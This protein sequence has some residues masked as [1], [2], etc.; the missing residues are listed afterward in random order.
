[1]KHTPT[2]SPYFQ[3]LL[4][5]CFLPSVCILNLF[6]FIILPKLAVKTGVGVLL[7]AS[8][9]YLVI[10]KRSHINMCITDYEY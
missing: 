10:K 4:D 8:L 7:Y 1:M 5:C 2:L 3:Y 9:I 6:L